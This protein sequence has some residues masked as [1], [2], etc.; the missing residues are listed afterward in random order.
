MAVKLYPKQTCYLTECMLHL[1]LDNSSSTNHHSMKLH[2]LQRSRE[3][4]SIKSNVPTH[5]QFAKSLFVIYSIL[6]Q[7]KSDIGVQSESL[8]LVSKRHRSI[9]V[10][11]SG[12]AGFRIQTS[13]EP[14]MC[15]AFNLGEWQSSPKIDLLLLLGL[16]CCE[17]SWKIIFIRGKPYPA[18]VIQASWDTFCLLS[19]VK[20][21]NNFVWLS[22]FFIFQVLVNQGRAR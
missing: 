10:I 18:H 15:L 12:T 6:L 11:S 9:P 21:K 22:P 14:F 3:Y 2:R 19:Y 16:W 5:H 13:E 7:R 4:H 1:Y 8:D 17:S 20:K